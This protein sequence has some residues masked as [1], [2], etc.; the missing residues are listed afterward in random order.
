MIASTP[1]MTDR[2]RAW[3][4]D[5]TQRDPST[6]TA[7]DR[8]FTSDM[9]AE[10]REYQR[11]ERERFDREQQEMIEEQWPDTHPGWDTPEGREMEDPR[12]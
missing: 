6:H 10:R 4:N 7:E 3:F 9:E 11:R 8:K 2:Q 12:L 5:L 1:W